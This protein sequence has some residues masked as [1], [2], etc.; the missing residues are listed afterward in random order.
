[1]PVSGSENQL[2]IQVFPHVYPPQEDSFFLLERA[3]VYPGDQVLELCCGCGFIGLNLALI[4]REVV[5]VDINPFAVANAR[6]NARMNGILNMDVREADLYQAV[7]DE[8]FDLIIANPPYVPTPPDWKEQ[9]IIEVSWNA[10]PYGRNLIDRILEELPQHLAPQ[11]RFLMVQSS[12]A[13]IPQTMKRL[14]ELNMQA[15]IVASRW[16]E[17]G[18]VSHS[19]YQWLEQEAIMLNPESELLVVIKAEMQEGMEAPYARIHP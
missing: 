6:Y 8:C 11:G 18:P 13:D 4:A 14:Q 7:P 16:L 2:P 9:D 5:S 17:L 15:E 3:T 12:L 19:R 1:M 10:G